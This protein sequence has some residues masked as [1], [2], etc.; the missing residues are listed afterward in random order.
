MEVQLTSNLILAFSHCL[1]PPWLLFDFY[2]NIF[3]SIKV[4]STFCHSKERE[5]FLF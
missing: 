4:I 1:T 5:G 3:L 2:I